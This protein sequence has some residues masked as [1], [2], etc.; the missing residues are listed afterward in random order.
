MALTQRKRRLLQDF[1]DSDWGS[2]AN[3]APEWG[4][5][6]ALNKLRYEHENSSNT[7][8]P[9]RSPA[10]RV[11][12]KVVS[13]SGLDG[14]GKTTH[15]E[16]LRVAL[17]ALGYSVDVEWSKIARDPVLR[18]L[19]GPLRVILDR[20]PVPTTVEPLAEKGDVTVAEPA[21]GEVRNYPDG[22]PPLPAGPARR[23]RERS[24]V[25]TWGWTLIVA[26]ANGLTHRR[27]VHR[28]V[29]DVVIC[30]RYVLDSMAHLRYRYGRDHRYWFQDTLIR[31]LSPRPTCSIFLDVAPGIARSR[32]PEQYTTS[33]LERLR[34]CYLEAVD[35]L[36]VVVINP[37][38]PVEKT[39]AEI[40]RIV[41]AGLSA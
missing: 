13:L 41:F 19:A 20:L 24:R 2:A 39:A 38:Q 33:D 18:R 40:G 22:S 31:I 29:R 21:G 36:P 30:D 1:S 27:V 6:Q 23:L 32:K 4:L 26:W 28:D 15:A 14:S 11:R 8:Q 12:P 3:E 25:V 10:R 5:E 37:D 17:E 35:K 7:A 16:H 9:S 34:Q